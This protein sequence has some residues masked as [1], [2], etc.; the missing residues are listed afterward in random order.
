MDKRNGM[1][2][3]KPYRYQ[4]GQEPAAMPARLPAA[5]PR[6]PSAE[7]CERCGYRLDARG[8]EIECEDK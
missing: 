7:R 2:V 1:P 6:P 4:G 8:H 3:G 5:A